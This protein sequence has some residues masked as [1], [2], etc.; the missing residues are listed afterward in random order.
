MDELALPLNADNL[1]TLIDDVVQKSVADGDPES[2]FTLGRDFITIEKRSGK[3]LG[4]FAKAM[5]Q[6]T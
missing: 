6:Y 3:A 5:E 2:A 1:F 4:Q